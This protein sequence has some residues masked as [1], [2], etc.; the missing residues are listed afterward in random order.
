MPLVVL[1]VRVLVDGS[2]SPSGD[3]G[4]IHLR[5]ADVGGHTPL[6]GSYSRFGF[7]QP[8]PLLFYLLALPYRLSGARFTGIEVGAIALTAAALGGIVS[9]AWR[10]AGT[11]GALGTG[12]VLAVFVHGLGPAWLAD[13]WEPHVLAPIVAA[14]IVFAADVVAG[15]RRSLVVVAALTSLMAQALSSMFPFALVL[16]AWAT[17]AVLV[18][19]RR[20]P[21]ARRAALRAVLAAGALAAVLW[22][23]SIGEQLR[24]TPGNLTAMARALNGGGATIGFPT[25]WRLVA[26]ELG[27][28]ATWLGFASP[29]QGFSNTVDVS[30]A[31]LVPVGLVVLL[32]SVGF[33][34]ARGRRRVAPLAATTVVALVAAVASF[35]RL[36]GPVFVWIPQWL[37]VIG[38]SAWLTSAAAIATSFDVGVARS[39]RRLVTPVAAAVL[40]GTSALTAVQA[41][42]EWREPDP[43]RDAVAVLAARG[44][45]AVDRDDRVLVRSVASAPLVFG[46]QDVAPEVLVLGLEQRGVDTLVDREL[47]FKFGRER[48]HP[49]RATVELRLVTLG[50]PSGEVPTPDGFTV[51]ATEDPLGPLRARRG[52]LLARAGLGPGASN[53]DVIDAVAADPTKR[54]LAVQLGRLPDLPVLALLRG[55]VEDMP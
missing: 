7:N 38:L 8:G 13:P 24:G 22:A 27:L 54:P 51:V 2:A 19:A 4:L 5:V 37:R 39:L 3:V 43:L 45:D 10:R 26:A 30:A 52:R 31:P 48:A 21:E 11:I 25:A 55:R 9:V 41:L 32:V 12:A 49:E 42:G 16:A 15:R 17:A 20:Q 18:Q 46:G 53:R 1:A 28:K 40:V 23:P 33:A 50:D 34:L 35:S 36:L 29:R 6:L 14:S 47:V 44:A